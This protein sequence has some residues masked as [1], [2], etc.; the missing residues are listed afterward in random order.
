MKIVVVS[1]GF[2]PVHSGHISYFNEA[3]KIGDKLIVALNSDEWLSIKKG[4]F[5][6]PF[7]ERKTILENLASVDEVIGFED[8][9]MGS[10]SDALE[11]IKKNH[12][13]D[14][15]IFCNGGDRNKGNIPEMSVDG[16]KFEFGIGGTNKINS[17]SLILKD[18]QF[19]SEERVWGKFYNIFSDTN[20]K[21]KELI[22][23]PG[24]GISYQRH[25]HRGEI[26]FVSSGECLIKYSKKDPEKTKELLLSK[27]EIFHVKKETWHQAIN[28]SNDEC[29]IIEIQYGSERNEEDIERHSYYFK[30]ENK[31]R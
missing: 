24:K 16:V 28:V 22:L 20:V 4:N 23:F 30:N 12:P 13:F 14:E 31:Q 5:F 9:F 8:D 11:K 6:M 19:E 29:H 15:I 1:G 10:C 3:K 2:D 27:H 25:F 17:S 26:W 18:F 21:V 7:N